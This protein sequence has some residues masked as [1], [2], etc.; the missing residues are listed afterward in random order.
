MTP[1]K[2]LGMP[3]FVYCAI[4][5]PE[6]ETCTE[7]G[8]IASGP[9]SSEQAGKDHTSQTQTAVEGTPIENIASVCEEWVWFEKVGVVLKF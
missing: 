9:S 1:I 7:P 3:K 6:I 4:L 5:L 2:L 8:T